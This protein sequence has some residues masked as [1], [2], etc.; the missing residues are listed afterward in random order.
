[1]TLIKVYIRSTCG[2]TDTFSRISDDPAPP[3]KLLSRSNLLAVSYILWGG[4]AEKDYIPL[5]TKA[6]MSE[7]RAKS[8]PSWQ[9]EDASS[10][11][12]GDEHDAEECAASLD[13]SRASLITR[14]VQDDSMQDAPIERKTA[15][16][17][18]KGSIDPKNDELEGVSR[19]VKNST[20][21]ADNAQVNDSWSC[22]KTY[23]FVPVPCV[24]L[25]PHPFPS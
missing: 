25:T 16:L 6:A 20:D 2:G 10:L 19:T 4:T 21:A 12:S 7:K 14:S 22:E 5:F 13:A 8:I 3:S 1:M 15:L 18:S 9:R 24:V 23:F 11:P 17:K